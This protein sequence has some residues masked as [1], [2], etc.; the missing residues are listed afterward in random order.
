MVD[1]YAVKDY[2]ARMIG[3]EHIIPTLGV[4]DKPEDIDWDSLPNQ[5]VLKTTHGGGGTGVVICKDKQVF[6]RGLAIKKLKRSMQ[7][8]IYGSLREWPY[9]DVPKRV[10]A[11]RY[12]SDGDGDLNDY[13][14]HCFNGIP[15]V[16]LLCRDRFGNTG[17]TEDFYTD[18]W[19]HMDVKRPNHDN[20]NEHKKPAE[21][22][23]MLALSRRLSEGIPFVRVDFYTIGNKV[24][25]GE[26]TF[27]PASGLAHFEPSCY[28]D[29]FGSWLKIEA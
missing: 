10:I 16:I 25:F 7:A 1:K 8:N 24:Y 15:R 12:M 11:E 22:E 5:F 14:V 21:L 26:L 17:M 19:E 27:F 6:D 18:Q 23:E 2:V 28:D 13:K 3:E 4:W 29:L 9:K 20:P